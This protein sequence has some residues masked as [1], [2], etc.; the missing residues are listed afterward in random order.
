MTVGS[1]TEASPSRYRWVICA[2]LFFATTINYIDRQVLGILAPTLQV[3]VGWSELQYSSIV[4]SFQAAYAVG[5]LVFGWLIDKVGS[6]VGLLLAVFA[7]SCASIAHGFVNT[8]AGFAMAR[9]AL[10]LSEAGNFPASVKSVAEWFPKRERAFAIGIFNSGSNVGAIVTPLVVPF[11][12]LAWGWRAAFILTGCVGILW[13]IAALAVWRPLPS[14]ALGGEDAS[15]ISWRVVASERATWGFALAKFLTDPIWWFYLYWAPK[16]LGSQFGVQLAGL[17]APLVVIYLMADVGSV[18]GGYA[19]ACLVRLGRGPLAARQRVM[20]WCACVA[21]LVGFAAVAPNLWIAVLLLGLATAAH[22]AWS[23]NLFAAVSDIFPKE[24]VA[25]VI[26][27]G[28]M[29][30]AVGGMVIATVTGLVL[31]YSGSYV[32]PFVLCSLSYIVAWFVFVAF[33]GPHRE[34]EVDVDSC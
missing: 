11:V 30:G 27:L 20:L 29:L 34:S 14:D 4:T 21:L 31:Q 33:V 6:R 23:A 5:L 26:G 16:Y 3:E 9:F 8:V 22:Q 2:L 19:S 13:L 28:G 18:M 25:S 7:W 24:S 17:A 12:A 10:G 15:D 32:V 1:A